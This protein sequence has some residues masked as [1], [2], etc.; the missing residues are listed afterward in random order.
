KVVFE[1]AG[2]HFVVPSSVFGVPVPR[3]TAHAVKGQHAHSRRHGLTRR[4][5][6]SAFA[7]RHVLGGVKTEDHRVAD[8]V[9]PV[10]R[11]HPYRPPLVMRAG[12]VS[13]ILDDVQ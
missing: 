8:V 1:T 9:V 6:H 2:D 11:H 10:G 7:G 12:S 4:G 3:I 13:G 5:D